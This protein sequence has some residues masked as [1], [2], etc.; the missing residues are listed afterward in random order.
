MTLLVAWRFGGGA[1]AKPAPP[2]APSAAPVSEK[3]S[4]PNEAGRASLRGDAYETT[5]R[6]VDAI[7]DAR[8]VAP[9]TSFSDQLLALH[10]R[11]MKPPFSPARS[12]AL[13]YVFSIALRTSKSETQW[14]M[15][16]SQGKAWTPDARVWN[17][18]EGSFDQR[19]SLV[20]TAPSMFTFRVKV[21]PSARLSFAQ[22]TINAT[23]GATVHVVSIVDSEG[24]VHEVCRHRLAPA[25]ARRWVDRVCDLA[26]FAGQIVDLRLATEIASVTKEEQRA[27][28][29]REHEGPRAPDG[30]VDRDAGAPEDGLTLPA[31]P[32]A[33]WGNPELLGKGVPRIAYNVLWI[34][35][36]ALRPDVIASFHDDADDA[37]KQAAAYP[38]LE[39]LLP[40]VPDLVPSIED[41]A[42][43]GVRFTHAYSAGSWTRPGTLA[44]LSGA[45]SGELGVDTQSW[46]LRPADV[47]RFY[48]SDPPLLP[49]LLRRQGAASRA[50]VNNYFMVGVAP[51]GVDMGFERVDDHR[52]RT[53]DTLEITKDATQWMRENHDRRF[54]AFVN[55]NSPH[56]P[57]EPEPRLVKRVP[58]PP[59]G[60]KDPVARLYMAEA[61]KDDE[62]IGVLMKTI[63][64]L[65][66]RER[67]IVIVTADH[68]ET[69]SSAHVGT[70]A[71]DKMPVRYHHA[72]SNYEETTRIPIIVVA[73]GLLPA[74][75]VVRDRVRNVDIAPT[76]LELLGL[77]MPSRMSGKSLVDLT[78]GKKEL[79]ERVIVSEGRGTRAIL[80]GRYRLLVR[81]GAAKTTYIGDR[82]V[83][84]NEELFDLS[85]DPG[86]RHDIATSKPDLVLEM[87]AR[88]TAALANVPVAGS[89]EISAPAESQRLPVIHLRFAA[90]SSPHRVSGTILVG[91]KKTK[92]KTVDVT[93]VGMGRD[94]FKSDG[95]RIELAV[96]MNASSAPGLDIV[97]D[98]PVTPVSWDLYLDDAPWPEEAV[99]GG[100]FGL[101]APSLRKG[102]LSDEARFAAYAPMPPPIDPTR[103][104]GLFVSRERSDGAE[105]VRETTDEGAEE[106][107][108]LLREWGYAH[109]SANP[110]AP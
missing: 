72:V 99:F 56:E 40:K 103:D 16:A 77:E 89:R 9:T 38:P 27:T 106:M 104:F 17:M 96:S 109:G 25:L 36:D 5:L 101:T 34:V 28:P 1:E 3:A 15:P 98:P 57:Y 65:G 44:M 108:R 6:L 100:P 11:K 48:A 49:L 69:M 60:P 8:V 46:V 59:L 32:V 79:E 110:A 75:A 68:G 18:N 42:S 92:P 76:L 86:E 66:L 64:E 90:G 33:L 24:K 54:F 107:A 45:R 31:V 74:G 39:A 83:T 43:R 70:S 58:A 35:V 95:M 37:T 80:R 67:T 30:G 91:D 2:F 87:R 50:F 78:K 47:Q 41:L 19:E 21:P 81:E 71:L 23:R 52:Y 94:S 12:D 22:G 10:W 105:N 84:V 55:Y 73:P 26:P 88:L 102:I 51:V 4:S 61:A 20:A 7:A 82:A 63:D 14:S 62:A 97:V 53:R 85:T 13:R 93:P 29:A